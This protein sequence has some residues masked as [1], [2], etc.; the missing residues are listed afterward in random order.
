VQMGEADDDGIENGD[1]DKDHGA[2]DNEDEDESAG[3]F[4]R[5]VRRATSLERRRG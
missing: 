3:H 5:V 2:T 1:G 4:R